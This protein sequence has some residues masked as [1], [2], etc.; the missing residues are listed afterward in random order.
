[1]TSYFLASIRDLSKRL[2]DGCEITVVLTPS[3][4]WYPELLQSY[5]L[6]SINFISYEE[7]NPRNFL[8]YELVL[9]SSWNF[10]KYRTF[11]RIRRNSCT[12]MSMDNQYKQTIKQ[13]A[14]VR[15][16]VGPK[17]IRYLMDYVFAAGSRQI[18]YATTLGF[19]SF[20]IVSGVYSYDDEIFQS[21]AGQLRKN[22]FCFVG[23]KVQ[24]KGLDLLLTAYEYYR[25]SCAE[26]QIPAWELTIAG[27]GQVTSSLPIGVQE[28]DYLDPVETARLMSA[29]KCFV[30]PS[31]FEPFGVVLTEASA[32]G[33]LLIAS[34][35]VGAADELITEGV[36]GYIFQE[37]SA[38]DLAKAMLKITLFS[39]QEIQ[40]GQNESLL[41]A[42]RFRPEAWSRKLLQI[43]E[44][45][46]TQPH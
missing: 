22:Q 24:V 2:D 12:V 9:I 1:M 10:K 33:C 18:K 26:E 42:Q 20:Q 15:S 5:Q 14:F 43:Y 45:H 3:D 16:G 30:L 27:P 37:D 34:T 40:S 21:P 4:D 36:N 39:S 32:S 28:L 8:D 25:S 46:S 35:A 29:S 41:R 11:A 38:S 7:F 6:P 17:Y 19:D 44:R 31:Y 23:R 13:M